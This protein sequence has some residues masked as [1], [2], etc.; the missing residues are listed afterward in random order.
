MIHEGD[1]LDRE[2]KRLEQ[3]LEQPVDDKKRREIQSAIQ[4]LRSKKRA[5]ER[6]H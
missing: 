1:R 2:L 6:P 4:H 5:W 3:Q